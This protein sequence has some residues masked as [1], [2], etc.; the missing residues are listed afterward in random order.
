MGDSNIDGD[1][2]EVNGDSGGGNG[3]D[4]DGSGGTSPSRQGAGT[5]TSIPR[6][7]SVA[8]AEVQNSFSKNADSSRVFVSEGNYMRM[9]G[10][11]G[12]PGPPHHVVVRAR[13]A[14]PL[15]VVGPWPP[16]GSPSV[17]VLRPGKI[18]GSGFV[19]SNS[20]NISCV[21]F[22][23]HKNSRKQGTGTVASRQY[24]SSGKMHKNA[25]KCNKTKSKWFINQ[26]GA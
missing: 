3:I 18:G 15:G 23:K 1:A 19:S 6:N 7:S 4:G 5:E 22:L 11:I 26:H 14:L 16:S 20:K 17:F 9:G 2:G 21:A 12:G 25:M 10:V 8:A 13:G 24:V